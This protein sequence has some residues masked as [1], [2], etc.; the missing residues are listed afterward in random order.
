MKKFPAIFLL[1]FSFVFFLQELTVS[2]SAAQTNLD[3]PGTKTLT[4][5]GLRDRVTVRRDERGI[6]YIEA[7][8]EE[9]L[10]FAQ[11]YVTAGDRLF[12]MDLVRR[13]ERGELSEVLG[14]A[15]KAARIMSSRQV[16]ERASANSFPTNTES[17]GVQG[18]GLY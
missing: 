14:S 11:G 6:P 7:K 12:Q 15:A 8:N 13:T 16:F 1:L 3:Q 18:F 4:M 9:D 17:A 5:A 2:V 10:Y